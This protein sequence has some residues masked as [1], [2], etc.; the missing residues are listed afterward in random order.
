[1]HTILNLLLNKA[2]EPSTIVGLIGLLGLAGVNLTVSS[3]MVGAI[4][5]FIA[6]AASLA[7]VIVREQKKD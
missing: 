2:K 6:A 5:G 7:L 3:E 4:S 1:M